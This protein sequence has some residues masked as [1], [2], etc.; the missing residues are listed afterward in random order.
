MDSGIGVRMMDH[1]GEG[2]A[3][4]HERLAS[5][6]AV[7]ERYCVSSSPLRSRLYVGLGSLFV[8]FA[9][10]GVW[11]P[12]WPTVSW[13]VPAAFLF[14]MSSERLFRWCLSNRFFGPALFDYYATGRTV[15]RHAKWAI[16]TLIALASSLSAWLVFKVSYPTDPGYGPAFIVAV[17][18]IGIWYV[19]ARVATRA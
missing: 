7:V 14:S 17:G 6:D 19:G 2:A 16:L 12:G 3:Q 8:L 1:G 18:L 13:A 9:L 4:G 10:I 15:P 11:V 5:I